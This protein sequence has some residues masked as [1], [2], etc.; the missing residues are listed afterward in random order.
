MAKAAAR[1]VK[2]C[3]PVAVEG[4]T[5]ERGGMVVQAMSNIVIDGGRVAVVGDAVRYPD[6]TLARI[7]S[8]AGSAMFDRGRSVALVGSELDNGDRI[9]GPEHKGLVLNDFA[10]KPIEGLFY[11][12]YLPPQPGAGRNG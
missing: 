10:D 9:V 6:G 1:R 12:H 4:S 8:G 2:G 3:Y 5:T 11:R 7:V